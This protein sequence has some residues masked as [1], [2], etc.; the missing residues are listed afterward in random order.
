MNNTK[1]NTILGEDLFADEFRQSL[2]MHIPHSS[3]N[4]PDIDKYLI[5]QDELINENIKLTDLCTDVIFDIGDDVSKLIFPYSRLY[6]DVERLP[7]VDEEMFQYGRG[8][9]YTKTDDGRDLRKVDD[10]ERTKVQQLYNN[11]HEDLTDL[12]EYRLDV[13]GFANIIDCHSF[14]DEPFLT[15]LN[16]SEERPDICIGVDDFHTPEWM[17]SRLVSFFT[18]M[19]YSVKINNPYSGTIVP[20]VYY[21]KNANV[22]S[23]MIEVNR[24]LFTCGTNINY[25]KVLK[26]NTIIKNILN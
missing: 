11:H 18:S 4:I 16:S 23:I 1:N 3:L 13:L 15:D 8:I 20:L 22:S 25:N 2:I 5:N 7:D 26:L 6:C 10:I 17:V 19:G 9:Y 12:V 24:K 14:S 21:K